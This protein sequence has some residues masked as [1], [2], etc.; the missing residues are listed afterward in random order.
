[1]KR[2]TLSGPWRIVATPLLALAALALSA[3]APST[4]MAQNLVKM[5][6]GMVTGIDQVGL[7]IALERGFSRSTAW[8]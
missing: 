7:P 2:L 3:A 5:K 8:T 6:A 1:M 4:A